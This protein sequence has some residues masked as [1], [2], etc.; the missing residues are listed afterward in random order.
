MKPRSL[1]LLFPVFLIDVSSFPASMA[2]G[3]VTNQYHFT[4]AAGLRTMD[5][6]LQCHGER[7]MKPVVYCLGDNCLYSKSHSLR[8]DYPPP[9]H[10]NRYAPRYLVERA[11]CVLENGRTTCL[12]CHD[13]TKPAPHLVRTGEDLC[14]I[15]HINR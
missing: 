14:R 2:C 6:C 12:S 11:G 9:M 15:C 10:S 13:L 1:W 7:K 3:S 8:R 4:D 5:D